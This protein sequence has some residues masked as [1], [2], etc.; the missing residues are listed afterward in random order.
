MKA[1]LY[2]TWGASLL[3]AIATISGI[4]AQRNAIKTIGEDSVPSILTAQRLKDSVAGMDANAVNEL[5]I[6]PG[7]T[8]SEIQDYQKNKENAIKGYE[9]RRKAFAERIVLAAENITSGDAEHKPIQTL[10]LGFGDYIAKIERARDLNERGDINGTLRVY[11]EVA[12]LVDNT[13]LPA[14]DALDKVNTEELEKTYHNQGIAAVGWLLLIFV[15]GTLLIVGLVT[16]QIF[17]NNRMRRI[18]NP[19]LLAATAI[20]L[21]FVGYTVQSLLSA[22]YNLKVAKEDA[23]DS[24]HALRQ[25]RALAYGANA[26]ESRYLLDKENAAKYEQ[27]FFA[28]VN[29]IAKLPQGKSWDEARQTLLQGKPLDGLTGFFANEINNITFPG[30]RDAMIA[31]ISSFGTYFNIDKQIRELEQS[32]KHLEAVKLCTGIDKGESNWAFDEFKKAHTKVQDI[33]KAEFDKAIAQGFKNV[34]NF[35]ITTIIVVLGISGLTLFGL[36]SRIN[37]YGNG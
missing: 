14:G 33:N 28:K 18:L 19:M 32:G 26:D 25:S 2:L 36:R 29:Q 24:L 13:L 20:A 8:P 17:L 37:E 16:I 30:E 4:Q 22:S 6:Q 21:L 9:E 31:T 3:L 10:Q 11:R 23:F 34:E 35:E 7:K 27:A 1:A 12:Q 15:S 5:L